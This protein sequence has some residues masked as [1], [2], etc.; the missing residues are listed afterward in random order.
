MVIKRYYPPAM[1][2]NFVS[3][4]LMVFLCGS[5]WSVARAKAYQI[6]VAEYKLQV[7]TALSQVKRVSDTLE[8]VSNST[9]LA[10]EQAQK[11]RAATE[12]SDRILEA[13]EKD[14]E[15]STE[16]VFKPEKESDEADS[17]DI[18]SEI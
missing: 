15:N 8:Q 17:E 12:K 13:V 11:I 9:A 14:I 2:W 5:A 3:F 16:Q 10:P 18:E 6:E 4:G 1:A 7:G